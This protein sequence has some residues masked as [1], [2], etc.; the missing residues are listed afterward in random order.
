MLSKDDLYVK[1]KDF[2][3][4]FVAVRNGIIFQTY[5]DFLKQKPSLKEI[6]TDALTS[7]NIL[8]DFWRFRHE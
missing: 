6:S 7:I 3:E 5:Y 8:T 2:F 1:A 4:Y